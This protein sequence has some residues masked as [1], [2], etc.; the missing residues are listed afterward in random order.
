MSDGSPVPEQPPTKMQ[1]MFDRL[2]ELAIECDAL[3]AELATFYCDCGQSLLSGHHEDGCPHDKPETTWW[4]IEL[5]RLRTCRDGIR[6]ER[7]A[8]KVEVERIRAEL[9]YAYMVVDSGFQ[10]GTFDF[11][12]LRQR[13]A[14]AVK[15]SGPVPGDQASHDSLEW[16][17]LTAEVERLTRVNRRLLVEISCGDAEMSRIKPVYDAAV[18][19]ERE[20]TPVSYRALIRAVRAAEAAKPSEPVESCDGCYW[21]THTTH[22]DNPCFACADFN[23]YRSV[24]N[25]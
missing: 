24:K 17:E 4:Q 1:G 15:P 8:L 2:A 5:E 12:V 22:P 3:K 16:D 18:E 10:R 20:N 11:S 7:D 9:T 13:A 25:G 19:Y 21:L 23:K 14:E 6:D